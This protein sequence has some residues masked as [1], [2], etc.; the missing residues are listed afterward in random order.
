MVGGGGAYSDGVEKGGDRV[1]RPRLRGGIGT[2]SV[3]GFPLV[4]SYKNL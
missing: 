1:R 3:L 4:K 2:L